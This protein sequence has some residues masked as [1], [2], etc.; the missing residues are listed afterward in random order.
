MTKKAEEMKELERVLC[1]QYPIT[2]KDQTEALL[3]LARKVNAM[4]QAFAF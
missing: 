3:N 4:N 2:F 1:I